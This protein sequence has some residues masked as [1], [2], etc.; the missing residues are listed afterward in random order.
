MFK[1]KA[2]IHDWDDT[3]TNS[4]E[5]YAGWYKD[6]AD[7]YG[8]RIPTLE[9]VKPH[10]AR[11]VPEI[12]A[13]VW[14]TLTLEDATAKFANFIPQRIYDPQ[15][16]VGVRE[17]FEILGKKGIIFGVLTSGTEF[18][19]KQIYRKYL[20]ENYSFHEFVLCRED[21]EYHKPDPKVFDLSLKLLGAR[22]IKKEEIVYVGDHTIDFESAKNADLNFVAVTTGVIDKSKFLDLGMLEKNIL[23]SFSDLPEYLG[24]NK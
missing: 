2:I 21:C 13:G 8:L 15:L 20:D 10:W 5:T 7:F 6:F 14:D 1:I 19:T 22:G 18:K 24:F 11:T 3:I 17:C 16:F 12:I 9:E 23:D 4:F